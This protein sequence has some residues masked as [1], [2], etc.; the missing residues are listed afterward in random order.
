MFENLWF[1]TKE[2]FFVFSSSIISSYVVC[3]ISNYPFYN[4]KLTQKQLI[5]NLLDS[6]FNFSV[7][8]T[9][10]ILSASL[11][12]PYM[13]SGNHTFIRTLSN[14]IEY[15]FWIELFYYSYH[16][17]LHV[18][19]WYSIIHAK[20]HINLDVYPLDTLSISI[21]D[22]TGMILTLIA[23]LWF[24]DVNLAEYNFIMY[25]YLT[26]SFLSHSKLLSSQHVNHHKKFKC[27]FSFLFPIF[28]YACGT[29][30]T[31]VE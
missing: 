23:P 13:D 17:F 7:I 8:A 28:D 21:L 19:N 5:N 14:I 24:V 9:E 15:S 16:R 31:R 10:V 1:I 18:S 29:L 30:D 3:L 2:V 20:H 6:S 11:Y 22:S 12:Y 25:V 26:G 4:P 27:N